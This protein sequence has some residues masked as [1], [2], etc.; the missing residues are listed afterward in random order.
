MS[1]WYYL[2][3][4]W[5]F[6]VQLL[7]VPFGIIDC[8]RCA[9]LWQISCI[10]N[11]WHEGDVVSVAVDIVDVDCGSIAFVEKVQM[12][13]IKFSKHISSVYQMLSWCNE[14]KLINFHVS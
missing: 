7:N 1:T 6:F 14:T 9:V 4:I 2:E 8:I 5:R 3:I 13:L 12:C 11:S 10:S